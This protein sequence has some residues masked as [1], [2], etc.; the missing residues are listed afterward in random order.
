MPS[1]WSLALAL[2][3]VM[4]AP[5]ARA[6]SLDPRC[7]P[8]TAQS[9]VGPG[10][11][12][13]DACQ[14]VVDLYT[15]LN[16]QLGTLIAGGNTTLGQGGALGG[17]G[18]F[19]FEVRGNAMH[20][21][22]PDV[23]ATGVSTG[24][25]GAPEAFVVDDKWVAVPMADVAV[26]LFGGIDLGLTRVGG[27]D[28]LANLAYLPGFT[29]RSVSVRTSDGHWKLGW[30]GRLGILQETALVPGVS[31]SYLQ[32]DMPRVTVT[33]TD[34][35]SRSVS[36]RNYDVR[37]KSWRVTIA[38][39][40]ALI[41]VAAGIGQDRYQA[42]ARL[43]YDVDGARPA[44]PFALSIR[45]KRTTAFADLSL[46]LLVLNLFGEVGRVTGGD[47]TTYNT[48]DPAA[49]AARWYGSIGVRIGR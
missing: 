1:R 44:Q 26:G 39:H 20:A 3:A 31:V 10:G 21:S 49:D 18:H 43:D 4:L 41:G 45:P 46:N 40:L 35:D 5:A 38:K 37:A 15:Y 12:G 11:D 22:V 30:G 19:V 28:A 16:T 25:A 32:R 6:Q 2:T 13:G 42:D 9:V 7:Q 14:K 29:Q 48:F 17:L 34:G 24:P 33:G 47:V 23:A 27:I 8:G 36:V